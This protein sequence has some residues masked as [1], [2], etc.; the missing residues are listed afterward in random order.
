MLRIGR[1]TGSVIRYRKSPTIADEL[2]ARVDHIEGDQPR[3][4]RRRDQQPD[5]EVEN[6]QDDV[7]K[8]AHGDRG[9]GAWRN[10]AKRSGSTAAKQAAKPALHAAYS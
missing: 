7:E 5:I 1:S 10:A 9:L 3:Q 6:E 8:R 2:V 4:H